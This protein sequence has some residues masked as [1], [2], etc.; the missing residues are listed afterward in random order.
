MDIGVKWAGERKRGCLWLAP[1]IVVIAVLLLPAIASASSSF[2]G[3]S[4]TS[5]EF[6]FSVGSSGSSGAAQILI[7]KWNGTS[8]AKSTYSNPTGA[9][10]SQL[11]AVSCRSTASCMAVGSYVDSGKATH[12]LALT[13]NGTS[14]TQT[15][16]S[17]QPS[18]SSGAEL[19]AVTCPTGTSGC[20]GAGS[21]TDSNGKKHGL[22]PWW[23]GT[24][25]SEL[26]LPM[27]EGTTESE[28]FGTVCTTVSWCHLVGS[29]VDG[30]GAR[31]PLDLKLNTEVWVLK[32]VPLPSGAASGQLEDV[33][34][35]S[36][37]CVSVGKY[38]DSSKVTKTYAVKYGSEEWLLANSPVPVEAVSSQL[39]GVSCSAASECRAVGSF[40]RNSEAL[41][42]AMNWNGTAWS[43]QTVESQTFG[44]L[45]VSLAAV[46]CPSS[47][48][49]EAVGS[50]TYGKFGVSRAV[51]YNLNGGTWG[52]IGADG[53]QREW[54]LSEL[55][56]SSGPEAAE[57]ADVACPS[58]TFCVRVGKSI[59]GSTQTSKAKSWNGSS[60]TTMTIVG[61]A[62]ASATELNGVSCTSTSSCRAVGSYVSAG[63]TKLLVQEWSGGKWLVVTAPAPAE[64]TSSS[65]SAIACTSS[66]SCRAVGSY[67]SGGVTKTLSLSWNG[68]AWSVTATPNPG[69]ATFSQLS[70]IACLSSS[71]CRAI[72]SYVE[73]GT[74]KTLALTWNGTSWSITTT[75]NPTGAKESKLTDISCASTTFCI[76]VGKTVNS[77]SK[78]RSLA[79]R[80]SGSSWSLS[81]TSE[82][83]LS[84]TELS[85]VW[86]ISTAECRAVGKHFEGEGKS[87]TQGSFL[88]VWKEALGLQYW[89]PEYV[90]S[91][92][93]ATRAGLTSVACYS[94][95]SCIAVG[96]A[97][98]QNLPMEELAYSY[99]GGGWRRIDPAS[100]LASLYGV[101]CTSSTYCISVGRR[102]VGSASE[103][104]V[105]RLEGVAWSKMTMPS[106]S[107]SALNDVSCTD[108]THCTAVGSQ[109][110]GSLAE[111]WNGSSWS[112]QTTVNPSEASSVQL[113]SVSC[114]SA[115]NCW[116]VGQYRTPT[117][118]L[119]VLSEEWNGTSW[120]LQA[121]PAPTE[122]NE[123]WLED[124]SCP[125][126]TYCIAVGVYKDSNG[127]PHGLAERWNGTTWR[128]YKPPPPVGAAEAALVGVSCT[129]SSNCIAVGRSGSNSYV[130]H[131]NG[132]E[133]SV[134]PSPNVSGASWT[135]PVDVSCPSPTKCVAVGQ[136]ETAS[137]RLPLVM[138]WDG[139]V[140]TLESAPNSSGSKY[141]QL[142]GVFCRR[143]VDCMAVGQGS[144]GGHNWEFAVR[145]LESKQ[146]TPDTTILSGPSG[147]VSS[148]YVTFYFN[149][150]E[151]EPAYE[152]S[153]DGSA[154]GVCSSPKN[155][156]ELSEGSHTFKVRAVDLAGNQDTTPAERTF[157]VNQP[158]ETTITS[159]MPSY[160]SGQESPITFTSSK[161]G[162]SFECSRDNEAFSACTSP[163]TW[164]KPT[165]A[166]HTFRV[167]A[168]DS[169]G[170]VDPT[171]ASWE[172]NPAVYPAAPPGSTLT[173][174]GDG[175]KSPS[176]FT[177]KA[178]WGVK[179]GLGVTGVTFQV[180]PY[181]GQFETIPAK[182]VLNGK[183]EEVQWP[184]K[185]SGSLTGETESVFFNAGAYKAARG[186][187]TETTRFRAIYDGGHEAAGY[188]EPVATEFEEQWGGPTDAKEQV[189]PVT[190]DL[191]TGGFTI[192]RTD[193]SIPV[194]GT[195]TN[196]EFGRVF[197][198][199][200]MG[201]AGTSKVLGGNWQP[202]VPVTQESEGEAWSRLVLE[203]EPAQGGE[204]A[205]KW[206]EVMGD[207][208]EAIEFEY[209]NG[210]YVAPEYAPELKLTKSTETTFTLTNSAGE[211]TVFTH[212]T[213]GPTNEYRV[214]S[215]STKT[216]PKSARMVYAIAGGS[217]HRLTKIIAPAPAGVTCEDETS[218]T[219]PG[220]RTLVLHYSEGHA[221][222][223]EDRLTS[224]TYYNA[225]GSGKGEA[226]AEY[227]YTANE[228]SGEQ[229]TSEWDP[230][231]S[232]NLK[233]KYTY[234]GQ[235]I[236]TLTPPGEEP[237][238]FAYNIK[239][240]TL[241]QLKS[242]SR[243]SL[244]SGEPTATTTIA[245]NVPVSGSGAP[246][247][248]SAGN[249]ATWGQTDY[250]VNA[251]AIF[252]PTEV[253]SSPPSSYTK[254]TI[255]Y[256]DPEGYVVNVASPQL[257][258]ASGPSITTSETDEHGN[259][260]R[261][262]GAQA[263]LT[264][265]SSST[266]VVTSHELDTTRKY[267]ADGSELL[268]E[269]GPLHEVKLE[270]GGRVEARTHRTLN[271]DEGAPAELVKTN[272]P[273][274]VTTETTGALIEG[275]SSD[276]EARVKK[277]EYNW[278]VLKPTAEIVDPSGLN[279]R[280]KYVYEAASGLLKEKRLPGNPEGGDAHTTKSIYYTAGPNGE[281][282]E[283][284]NRP[285]WAG[286]SCITMPAAQPI[287][288]ESNPGVP[289]TK[290]TAYSALGEPTEVQETTNGELQRTT[291]ST[292]DVAGRLIKSKVT[293]GGQ[294]LPATETVYS[295]TTG[296]PVTQRLVCEAPENC[297][298]FDS[299]AT[300]VTYN[301][302]G[303]A[304][305]YEDADGN[306]STTGYDLMGRP[307]IAYD[308]KGTRTTSYD[309]TSG[310]P[311]QM[312]DS[313]AGTFTAS[314]NADGNIVT[315]GLPNGLTA[316]TTYGPTGA[317]IHK[318]YQ[319]TSNCISN[320]TWLDLRVEESI[321]GQWLKETDN[322]ESREYS[323][324]KAGRLT[325]TK[326]RPE[327][328]E[329]TTRTYSYD[330]DSNRTQLVTRT[331]GTGGQ[332]E[333]SGTGTT[334]AYT[335]DTADRLIGS[336]VTYDKLGRI[337]SLPAAY[338]GG[339]TLTT[340]F[341]VNNLVRSQSQNGLTNTYELDATGRQHAV[342][343]TGTQSGISIFHY[344]G[345]GDSP[346]WI[347]EGGS[348]TRN[349]GGF[350]G[351]VAIQQSSGTMT[352]QLTNLHGD[353][354]A[355]A[356]LDPN[357]T[358]PASTKR[359]DEFGTPKQS[360]GP[361]YGW[362]GGD[363]RRT[364]LSSGTIQ[365]GV[366]SYV[367]T[368][369]RFISPDPI[370][371][372][373]ANAYD[374]A[375]QSPLNTFDLGGERAG[376]GCRTATRSSNGYHE[377]FWGVSHRVAQISV[378]VHW[379]WKHNK[380]TVV[381]WEPP[382]FHIWHG[383]KPI[384]GWETNSK[385]GGV[386]QSS[387]RYIVGRTFEG[388]EPSVSLG[389]VG[390]GERCDTVHL[391]LDVIVEP[392]ARI[393]WGPRM[394]Q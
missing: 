88:A 370:P 224:L 257:P 39:T 61:P 80:F 1:L 346:A 147:E 173:S 244:V 79:E 19:L 296:Y 332:C 119:T 232:P 348:W 43:E 294:S 140:W 170:H 334:Q 115:G 269:F 120:S 196:L 228:I 208:E 333:T 16:S 254:A 106:V 313:A 70:G 292:Y 300:T 222:Y 191:L 146:E 243:P 330:A 378:T 97:N 288:T 329:C 267:S 387:A 350:E 33:S 141:T 99:E 167:R 6:C 40:E 301:A 391:E 213:V 56:A 154:Y 184:L 223:T 272:D 374:Y 275:Q 231:V 271:Y 180:K 377:N 138:G 193:F 314:Y 362:L 114:P 37:S 278:E 240:Y 91:P 94:S 47:S 340:S 327:G 161:A 18:G 341:Y 169:L 206:A 258:G 96:A 10:E 202:S 364:E 89:E 44:A 234:E 305:E 337:T 35:V 236:K 289:I 58:S 227:G 347:S 281:S 73:S 230:R 220:C 316:E 253:P 199:Q 69:G 360:N 309:S 385:T 322:A 209:V 265:L 64:A 291:T 365:M 176:Y 371:G 320:C 352:L 149:S 65:L 122:A 273:R 304:V 197:D 233:E 359:F 295:S 283:C 144:Y 127:A 306:K 195:E 137:G 251:T 83:E 68:T 246:Y 394:S 177:L 142:E 48:V 198:S 78:V 113:N 104:N 72:G 339:N 31:K 225:S 14:W 210:S 153:L 7:E 384:T 274:L 12:P 308:G 52:P 299:Q 117:S 42:I 392:H 164:T 293:G 124:L 307:A 118:P 62:E 158:P 237:F 179:E 221:N 351:L 29:Y 379:C 174:P 85:G 155:Y 186:S 134:L 200:Y 50:L 375:N 95:L 150:T 358:G 92:S 188:S 129:S 66:T 190:L 76:A 312:V 270:S 317:P 315:A 86:C 276:A 93:G 215:V 136:A 116:A 24:A 67:V 261:T 105:W 30:T 178:K 82:I 90:E 290:D 218:T 168:K 355:T 107:G 263:R 354:V 311:T 3:T 342:T 98:G 128:I 21:Y 204:P 201:Q 187:L 382:M 260:V 242:I 321:Y 13:W 345:P 189:G 361:R 9:V 112:T 226:V 148:G 53:Y 216:T 212:N 336:G 249:V 181:G 101:T 247:N 166:W 250:P 15:G 172:F 23:S 26:S 108:S 211:N 11:N 207:E 20:G 284:G 369:G 386:G 241:D 318:R 367:P 51:A 393:R 121:I 145:S 28:F 130:V 103:Q 163:Y 143:A 157:T 109:T 159:A 192:H 357:A 156:Q 373:S 71:S 203:E 325:L 368:M 338:A 343:Q 139:T 125:S 175:T 277:Y 87:E 110:S 75:P 74:T 381:N 383:W 34:C 344:T 46:S 123:N 17:P 366:R 229:L 252:P 363:G 183:G 49:C 326:E 372:G 268:E 165:I 238:T 162:S 194:P 262:L 38:V 8:W 335:Y 390:V 259:V 160:T 239:T 54:T 287:P 323:Y 45:T 331:L 132:S 302:I 5:S 324:D 55:P 205:L 36:I 219:T 214:T 376:S 171:P 27:P 303:E 328:T 297:T 152:C 60:W 264:A 349:I 319:K 22:A 217:E 81:N 248:M 135:I 356:S 182:Y 280:T 279:L 285:E 111:R 298:G 59:A 100:V 310:A 256:M 389:P 2:N 32:T 4:C 245:Y 282:S 151:S 25:W 266:P 41:P 126:A 133:W 84:P 380:L 57:Q 185:E 255:R 63:V 77:E 388:C 235:N 131:W 286:L 353:I 102:L